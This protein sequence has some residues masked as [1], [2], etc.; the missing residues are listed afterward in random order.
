MDDRSWLCWD[1]Y[2]STVRA[3]C[4]RSQKI[5]LV[6]ATAF[7]PPHSSS[8]RLC[9]RC[10]TPQLKEKEMNAKNVS[11]VLALIIGLVCALSVTIN[12]QAQTGG[13]GSIQGTITDAGGSVLPG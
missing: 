5:S 1:I 11:Q 8:H 3:R 7:E 2:P 12:V 10:L 4:Q 13:G 9:R 6:R